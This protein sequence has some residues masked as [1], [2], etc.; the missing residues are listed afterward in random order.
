MRIVRRSLWLCRAW[1]EFLFLIAQTF[2]NSVFGLNRQQASSCYGTVIPPTNKVPNMMN[3]LPSVNQLVGQP[4]QHS[5]STSASHGHIGNYAWTFCM[6]FVCLFMSGIRISWE[7]NVYPLSSHQWPQQCSEAQN[8]H[9]SPAQCFYSSSI[10]ITAFSL[11][12]ICRNI[13]IDIIVTTLRH[14]AKL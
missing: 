3:K 1:G 2:L 13:L 4:S 8:Q 7:W 12:S 11:L 5:P 10:F 9:I 6:V 14:G